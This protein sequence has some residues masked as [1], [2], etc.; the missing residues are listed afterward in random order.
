MYENLVYLC[1]ELR[2]V[3]KYLIKIGASRRQGDIALKKLKEADE[4]VEQF[5]VNLENIETSKFSREETNA[6]NLICKDFFDLYDNILDLLKSCPVTSGQEV[7]MASF[8]LKVALS[9][10]QVSKDDEGSI[11]QLIDGIE[12]YQS[13]LNSDGKTKLVNFVLKSRLSQAAKMKL[14]KTY[15]SV[16]ELIMALKTHLLPKKCATSLQKKLLNFRQNELTIDEFG[17]QITEMFVDL[18]I[19]QADGNENVATLLRKINEKQAI[20]TFA[21]GLRNRRLSTIISA[22]NFDSISDAVQSA[23]DEDISSASTSADVMAMRQ[24]NIFSSHQNRSRGNFYNNNRGNYMS[25]R[26]R[27]RPLPSPPSFA[28]NQGAAP[29]QG[30]ARATSGGR[31]G[32][33]RGSFRSSRGRTFFNQSRSRGHRQHMHILTNSDS[34]ENQNV[35]DQPDEFFRD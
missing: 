10:L 5:N 4:L 15:S 1:E 2:K 34:T 14:A 12:Y 7:N 33:S 8:D 16:D 21:N 24:N 25:G 29:W 27:V 13:E 9:L 18:T 23:I 26:G 28:N 30:S 31:R 11:N 6:F 3:R 32:A 22:K 35:S 17:K 19:S 20:H